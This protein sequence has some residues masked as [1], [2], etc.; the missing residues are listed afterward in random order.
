MPEPISSSMSRTFHNSDSSITSTSDSATIRTNAET[1]LAP[2]SNS[3]KHGQSSLNS[4]SLRNLVPNA[5]GTMSHS[6]SI[7]VDLNSRV[8]E[9][10]GEGQNFLGLA[11]FI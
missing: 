2:F 1:N 7:R 10:S 6:D 4:E 5:V 3:Q 8:S 9:S 11:S